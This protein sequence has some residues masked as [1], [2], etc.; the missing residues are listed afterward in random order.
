[1]RL[2]QAQLAAKL[3]ITD[4]HARRWKAEGLPGIGEG[5]QA[6]YDLGAVCAWMVRAG[7]TAPNL[8]ACLV[9]CGATPAVASPSE[10]APAPARPVD[11]VVALERTAERAARTPPPPPPL[12]AQPTA[13]EER[14]L[15]IEARARGWFS[16]ALAAR[17]VQARLESKKLVPSPAQVE[18]LARTAKTLNE[19]VRGEEGATAPRATREVLTRALAV[20]IRQ[21]GDTGLEALLADARALVAAEPQPVPAEVEG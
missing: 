17:D 12:S 5:R 1:M 6:V 8:D 9:E 20:W 13:T 7:K 3:G 14:R 16:A 4:R 11:P 21:W 19:A 15:A 2:T 18:S 10:P